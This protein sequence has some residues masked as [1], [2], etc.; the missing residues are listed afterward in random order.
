MVKRR[1]LWAGGWDV[2]AGHVMWM[3]RKIGGFGK[4]VLEADLCYCYA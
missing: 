1:F 4:M 3:L 2:C